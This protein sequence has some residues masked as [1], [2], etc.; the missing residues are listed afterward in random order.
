MPIVRQPLL[1]SLGFA[2]LCVWTVPIASLL[3]SLFAPTLSVR[4]TL[5][6]EAAVILLAAIAGGILLAYRTVGISSPQAAMSVPE[7]D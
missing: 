3:V 6:T 1:L 7:K 4:L 5:M 2:M